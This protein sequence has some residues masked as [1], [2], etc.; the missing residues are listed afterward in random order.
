[1]VIVDGVAR[2]LTNSIQLMLNG[3]MLTPSITQ[4]SGVTTISAAPPGVLPF[5]SSN[6][7]TLVFSDNGSP[8]LTRTNAWSFTV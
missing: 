6:N 5:L 8:S 7:V 2:V 3:A 4:T 1:M